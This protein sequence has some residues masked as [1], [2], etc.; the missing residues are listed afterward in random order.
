MKRA[1]EYFNS[2]IAAVSET[3]MNSVVNDSIFTFGDGDVYVNQPDFVNDFE[4]AKHVCEAKGGLVRW[5]YHATNGC[6]YDVGKI[7]KENPEILN[8]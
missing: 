7:V 8:D 2:G 1:E 4:H 3:N 5:E 6:V